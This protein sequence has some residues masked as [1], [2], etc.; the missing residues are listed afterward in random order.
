MGRSAKSPPISVA[1]VSSKKQLMGVNAVCLF[2]GGISAESLLRM[3]NDPCE[4]FPHPLQMLGRTP[5]W[6]VE[7]MERYVT[8]KESEVSQISA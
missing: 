1:P 6:T 4:R 8:K 5:M 3:R 7:Q 2:L